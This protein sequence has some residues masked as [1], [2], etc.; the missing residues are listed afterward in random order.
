M[1]FPDLEPLSKPAP[2]LNRQTRS[3]GPAGLGSKGMM[4]SCDSQTKKS[5]AN[6]TSKTL[7]GPEDSSHW[8]DPIRP[9]VAQQSA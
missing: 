7:P 9:Q 5:S 2:S 6:G 3:D 1:I 8:D 4:I